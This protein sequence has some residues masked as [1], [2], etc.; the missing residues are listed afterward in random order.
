MPTLKNTTNQPI[1]AAT[2]HTVPAN[3][4]LPVSDDTLARIENEPYIAMKIRKGHLAIERD[5]PKEAEPITRAGLAKMNR[6][7]L[8]D[9]I[10]A[11]YPDNVT[12]DDFKGITVEDK[13]GED[14]LRT[15]AARLVFSDL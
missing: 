10:L 1:E 5:A 14:G 7:E 9:V 3:G 6:G 11:H 4:E 13:D 15:I 12:E 2:G 8:L